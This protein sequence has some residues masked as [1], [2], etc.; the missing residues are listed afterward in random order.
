MAVTRALLLSP[1]LTALWAQPGAAHGKTP[2]VCREPGRQQ[3]CLPTSNI[4][5]L[6]ASGRAG[7]RLVRVVYDRREC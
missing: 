3:C 4:T 2:A 6:S 7:G 1:L 5:L